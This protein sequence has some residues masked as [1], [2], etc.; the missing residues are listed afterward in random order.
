MLGLG[1]WKLYFPDFFASCF[2]AHPASWQQQRR[3][4]GEGKTS[5]FFPVQDWSCQCCPGLV[6][7]PTSGSW[8][9]PGP[10]CVSIHPQSAPWAL[11]NRQKQLGTA[12]PPRSEPLKQPRGPCSLL[13]LSLQPHNRDLLLVSQPFGTW[14]VNL[15]IKPT[16]LKYL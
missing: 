16:L 2:S 13:F 12:H 3:S 10:Q 7:C 15:E 14:R 1:F 9:R 11:L 5:G 8:L 6:I 4:Q